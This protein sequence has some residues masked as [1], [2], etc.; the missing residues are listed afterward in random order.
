MAR[1]LRPPRSRGQQQRRS[2]LNLALYF[3]V[4]VLL[5][6][7]CLI[8]LTGNIN[9]QYSGI[10]QQDADA[11][12]TKLSEFTGHE[13]VISDVNGGAADE[14]PPNFQLA[15]LNCDRYGG[16]SEQVAKELVYWEDIPSD[17]AYISPFKKEGVTQYLTF[18]PDA[19]GW[20]NIRSK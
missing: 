18:E 6:A 7:G 2:A 8:F 1:L 10:L 13:V 16:P 5:F 12:L 19:G 17:A 9:S 14:L 15:G 3:I 20:N 11:V 4:T